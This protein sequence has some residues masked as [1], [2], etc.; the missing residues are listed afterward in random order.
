EK[1]A[2]FC[3]SGELSVGDFDTPSYHPPMAPRQAATMSTGTIPAEVE[4]IELQ[5]IKDALIRHKGNKSRVA[6][7]LGISRSYLYKKLSV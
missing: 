5:L 4:N 1:A 3:D 2:I 6:G 7:E